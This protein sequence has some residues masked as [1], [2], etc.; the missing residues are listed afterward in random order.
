MRYGA[1][2]SKHATIRVSMSISFGPEPPESISA[3]SDS[4]AALLPLENRTLFDISTLELGWGPDE[5]A[6]QQRNDGAASCWLGPAGR[7]FRIFTCTNV[8]G[9]LD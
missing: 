4:F 1:K 5:K 6:R 8:S 7:R 2:G 9:S 3:M